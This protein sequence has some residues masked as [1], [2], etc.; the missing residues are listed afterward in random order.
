M[1]R[2]FLG[3]WICRDGR[4]E[5]FGRSLRSAVDTVGLSPSKTIHGWRRPSTD[6]P[7]IREIESIQKQ[8]L[9][10]LPICLSV[11]SAN[12]S[13]TFTQR[14]DLNTAPKQ[15][16]ACVCRR[17]YLTSGF[18]GIQIA[19]SGWWLGGCESRAVGSLVVIR[20]SYDCRNALQ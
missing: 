6:R 10:Q 12:A 4:I 5:Q 20:A 19:Q 15:N 9:D 8:Y 13:P 3:L 18:S 2:G 1:I 14:S 11:A 17:R 7:L 16:W